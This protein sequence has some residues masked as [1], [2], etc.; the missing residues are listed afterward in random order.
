MFNKKAL[1]RFGCLLG[2]I[3]L[4]GALSLAIPLGKNRRSLSSNT[5]INEVSEAGYL[6]RKITDEGYHYEIEDSIANVVFDG[7]YYYIIFVDDNYIK[8][9]VAYKI[10]NEY[11]LGDHITVY[12]DCIDDTY[13]N[14]KVSIMG[15]DVPALIVNDEY[16]IGD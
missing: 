5:I 2:T 6:V 4:I 15:I 12:R 16:K 10:F 7:K 1:S 3:L 13:T 11:Q 9:E 8:A 14:Y